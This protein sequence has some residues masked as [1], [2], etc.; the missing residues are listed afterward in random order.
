[1]ISTPVADRCVYVAQSKKIMSK[2]R[3]SKYFAERLQRDFPAIH[4]EYRAGK[5]KSIRQA[6]IMAGLVRKPTRVD[7]LRREWKKAS[8]S[9]QGEFLV[10]A[11]AA[12]SGSGKRTP[13]VTSTG[14]MTTAVINYLNTWLKR[15]KLRPGQVMKQMGFSNYDYRLASALNGAPLSPKLVPSLAGWLARNGF[16]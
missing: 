12:R 4:S 2:K 6:A 10:W 5:L 7:A 16:K 9:E 3:D 14:L 11:R 8:V 13:I 1:M 15:H